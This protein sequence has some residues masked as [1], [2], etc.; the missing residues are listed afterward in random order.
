M[1][2][3]QA[4]QRAE[5]VEW[6]E[7]AVEPEHELVQVRLQ[8]IGRDAVVRAVD[9][10]LQVREHEV[11]DRQVVLANARLA[12][13]GAGEVL[14]PEP[15][16]TRVAL[17]PVGH[18]HLGERIDVGTDEVPARFRGLVLDDLETQSPR[19]ASA[20]LGL[21]LGVPRVVLGVNALD[22][23]DLH[24][25]G[26]DHA[27]LVGDASALASRAPADERL[28]DLDGGTRAD[29]A[30]RGRH[31]GA[32]L[33]ED[34]E[35]GLVTRQAELALE[36]DGG[37]PRDLCGDQERSPEPRG[38]RRV[39]AL[40]DGAGDE[41]RILL[42]A[43]A[44]ELVW[45]RGEPERLGGRVALRALKPV[46]PADRFE[47]LSARGVVREHLLKAR[48]GLRKLV[49]HA[50]RLH[51]LRFGL[52]LALRLTCADALPRA[53]AVAEPQLV[54]LRPGESTVDRRD[55][56]EAAVRVDEVTRRAL[57]A[58][59]A[60]AT[61]REVFS[62]DD[63]ARQSSCAVTHG[64]SPYRSPHTHACTSLLHAS[65][66]QPRAN[67]ESGHTHSARPAPEQ[68][69]DASSRSASQ[70][71]QPLAGDLGAPSSEVFLRLFEHLDQHVDQIL[72][73][74]D[75]AAAVDLDL[76]VLGDLAPRVLNLDGEARIR[77]GERVR[78]RLGLASRTGKR[79]VDDLGSQRIGDIGRDARGDE[80]LGLGRLQ[81]L[82]GF[83]HDSDT[84]CGC[85]GCQPD[86]HVLIWPQQL[87]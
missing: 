32:E 84:S 64:S 41:A 16:E 26:A 14:V 39:R 74:V 78:E 79:V 83:R 33:V 28:V 8:V 10:R 21:P 22:L 18:D 85:V 35:R 17:R 42:A 86:K 31:A 44:A 34:L 38:E 66:R 23:A 1:R 19:V 6:V 25:D 55:V 72:I 29:A 87:A 82:G 81:R 63:V 67:H 20:A 59:G 53:V 76:D 46:A 9:P 24:L 61:E 30:A 58:D 56:P 7:P 57:P 37:H 65:R 77:G 49:G 11:D 51:G 13:L 45:P 70:S 43:L 50:H 54:R 69:L 71:P 2:A 36:L 12:A 47:V 5:R 4:E 15:R 52:A 48:Q 60:R 3:A 27:N 68:P 73:A 62:R 75:H 40:H 80:F